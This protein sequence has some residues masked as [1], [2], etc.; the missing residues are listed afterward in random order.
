[1]NLTMF[2]L[3]KSEPPTLLKKWKGKH[4]VYRS[5]RGGTLSADHYYSC[6]T[7]LITT[8]CSQLL[9]TWTALITAT[10]VFHAAANVNL[11]NI[12]A[13]PRPPIS[14]NKRQEKC[15]L[16]L[17]LE[18]PGTFSAKARNKS[19]LTELAL[20]WWRNKHGGKRRWRGRQGKTQSRTTP[21]GGSRSGKRGNSGRLNE[22]GNRDHWSNVLER[23]RSN[24]RSKW[25]EEPKGSGKSK[26]KMRQR[27]TRGD[28]VVSWKKVR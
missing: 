18:S 10:E 16:G 5:V 21:R 28:K 6:P 26:P 2:E 24:L 19:H 25:N 1:M 27:K 11:W 12:A 23:D 14:E 22:W 15:S 13:K 7:L 4:F 20:Y 3:F 8:S 17:S 9:I